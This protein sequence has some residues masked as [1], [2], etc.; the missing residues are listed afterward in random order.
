MMELNLITLEVLDTDTCQ[1]PNTLSIRSVG[2]TV[3]SK[4]L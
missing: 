4:L 2:C 1:T 3:L